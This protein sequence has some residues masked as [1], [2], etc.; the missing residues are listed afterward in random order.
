MW[1]WLCGWYSHLLSVGTAAGFPFQARVVRLT[2]SRR[3]LGSGSWTPGSWSLEVSLPTSAPS[4]RPNSGSGVMS[5]EGYS[6]LCL[7]PFALDFREE[8]G[9]SPH[10][11]AHRGQ[12]E[13]TKEPMSDGV[14]LSREIYRK[15]LCPFHLQ[16]DHSHALPGTFRPCNPLSSGL[17]SLLD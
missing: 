11:R 10:L 16:G 14:S 17:T 8:G 12:A 4:P 15:R 1:K 7:G 5:P 13:Q 6:G 3:A 2:D 9:L